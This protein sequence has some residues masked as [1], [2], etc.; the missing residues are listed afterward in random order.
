MSPEPTAGRTHFGFISRRRLLQLGLAGGGL[1]LAGAGGF[2]V[3][4]G[5]VA[6]VEGLRV[7]GARRYQTLAAIARAHLP[8]GG[9]FVAG[10]DD[11]D[12]ARRF[13]SFLADEPEE[14]VRDLGL[15]LTLVELGPLL[16]D[17]RLATFSRLG[18]AAQRE[19]WQRRW[20]E[21]D[22]LLRR[23]A[24]LAFRKFMALV[25][26]DEP[27]VWPHIGYPGPRGGR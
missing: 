19:H 2:R 27:A 17:R 13:D 3:V 5:T 16:F 18:P 1:A 9:P 22:G 15:A 4:A 20:L 6:P 26:Y 24:A 14:N 21:S 10:A 12:L 11:F 23:K 25:F 8:S 7:L